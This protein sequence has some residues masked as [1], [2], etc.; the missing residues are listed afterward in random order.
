MADC[1]SVTVATLV[2]DEKRAARRSGEFLRQDVS[3]GLIH[4]MDVPS[5]D[6]EAISRKAR[7]MAHPQL[8]RSMSKEKQTRYT[9][10]LKWATCRL[11]RRC[12]HRS[13]TDKA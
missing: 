3:C 2:C 10:P 12:T 11:S 6:R 13:R 4:I 1:V 5:A 9:S 8:F 7:E